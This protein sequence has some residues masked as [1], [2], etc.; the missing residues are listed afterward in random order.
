VGCSNGGG[1]TYKTL[2]YYSKN[3]NAAQGTVCQDKPGALCGCACRSNTT[4][5]VRGH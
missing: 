5:Y 3:P 1:G 4:M 2:T